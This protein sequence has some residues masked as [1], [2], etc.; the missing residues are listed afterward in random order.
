CAVDQED[1]GPAVIVVIEDGDAGAGSL[2]NVLLGLESAKNVRGC[3]AGFV[4]NVGEM[5]HG[6]SRLGSLAA[7]RSGYQQKNR[8]PNHNGPEHSKDYGRHHLC[9]WYEPARFTVKAAPA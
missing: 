9:R 4:G 6:N 3:Q 1:V 8:K 5:G 2:D 7:E